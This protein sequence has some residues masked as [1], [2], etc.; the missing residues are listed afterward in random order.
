[1]T[2]GEYKAAI[3]A[4]AKQYK[5]TDRE[6]D[7]AESMLDGLS[8]LEIE[9]KYNLSKSTVK[10]HVANILLKSNSKSR[11][12]FIANFYKLLIFETTKPF[13]PIILAGV[14]Q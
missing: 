1:M 6:I 12:V 5:F 4:I 3:L 2:E 7:I 10:F 8:N 14:A 11:A 13:E 9:I